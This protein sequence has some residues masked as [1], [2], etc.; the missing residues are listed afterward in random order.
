MERKNLRVFIKEN[1]YKS[2]HIHSDIVKKKCEK[3]WQNLL[4][5]FQMVCKKYS[6]E[7]KNCYRRS[8]RYRLT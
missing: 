7:L 4:V 2:E 6:L 5:W 1:K 8:W 3:D